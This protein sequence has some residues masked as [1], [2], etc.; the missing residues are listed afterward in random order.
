MLYINSSHSPDFWAV[1]LRKQLH[2]VATSGPANQCC[3]GHVLPV[4]S[5]PAADQ[6]FH[7]RLEGHLLKSSGGA[8]AIQC[9]PELTE[10]SQRSPS[11]RLLLL[12]VRLTGRGGSCCRK[13]GTHSLQMSVYKNRL[14][15]LSVKNWSQTDLFSCL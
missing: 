9:L 12:R 5:P 4:S 2:C 8:E 7:Q 14:F 13:P 6:C 15:L 10:R 3:A 11:S 1:S